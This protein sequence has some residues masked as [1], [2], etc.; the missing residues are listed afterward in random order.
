MSFDTT[1]R[2]LA[3]IFPQDFARWLL[4]YPVPLTELKPT[5]LSMEPSSKTILRLRACRPSLKSCDCGKFW[6]KS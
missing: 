6:R 2:R 4:G 1:C 3:K 5:E